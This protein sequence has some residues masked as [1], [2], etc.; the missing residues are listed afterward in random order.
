MKKYLRLLLEPNGYVLEQVSLP[1]VPLTTPEH[2]ELKAIAR[3]M[4]TRWHAAH[5]LGFAVNE[6]KLVMRQPGKRVKRLLYVYRVILAGRHL[7]R[8]GEVEANLPR[9]NEEQPLPY[10]S[11]LIARKK[12]GPENLAMADE[13][14]AFH[15]RENVRIREELRQA[16]EE[17]SLPDESTA[18]TALDDLL[19]RLRLGMLG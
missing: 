11:E 19:V 18:G 15:E 9:L 2:E 10:I 16:G 5:Y 3:G 12:R 1:L 6:W 4:I 8:T 17:S 7:L 14:L 13:E